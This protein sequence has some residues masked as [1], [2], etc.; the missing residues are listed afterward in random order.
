M[1]TQMNNGR[2]SP[3]IV[4]EITHFLMGN[5][6]FSSLFLL[7][8]PLVVVV[9]FIIKKYSGSA[10]NLPPGPPPWPIIGN[11]H[12]IGESPQVS[13][14]MFA[15]QYGPLISLHLGTQLLVV[16]SSPEAAIGILKSHDHLLSCRSI[17]DAIDHGLAPFFFVWSTDCGQH[18]KSL[19]TLSRNEMFSVKALQAQSGLR[20]KKVDQMLGFLHGKKGQVVNIGDLVFTTTFNTL[21]NVF[22]GKDFLD[23]GDEHGIAGGLKEKLNTL[24]AYGV[25]PNISDFFPIFK[26][27]DLQG[28]RK[29]HMKGMREVFSIWEHLIDERRAKY[30]SSMTVVEDKDKSFL[31]RL[32][33]S[34]FT[35]D[36]IN[37]CAIDLFIAGTDTTSSTVEWAMAELLK[38]KEAMNKLQEELKHKSD[39]NMI[40]ESHLS[41]FP[42]LN[43]CIKE[44]LRLHPP[45]PLLIPRHASETCEVMN[46]TIPQNTKIF[47]NVW[48]IGRDPKIW[49]DPL[50]FKPE[51]FLGSSLDFKGQDFEFIPFGAGRR[52]CPGTQYGIKSVQSILA[53]LIHQFDWVLPNDDDPTKLDM[54]EKF[55]V[56]LQREKPLQLIV[57]DSK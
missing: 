7:L 43:A 49:E 50:S 19:R 20:H 53:S 31:D 26:R 46:Y 23:F 39:S 40:T 34:G 37:I 25:R 52:M 51:R 9:F 22:F 11:I 14:A 4:M 21:S 6:L 48:T 15:Q 44:T 38:N 27:W 17:P 29:R 55:G 41:K 16:A 13:M 5:G 3:N 10:K 24:L 56:T 36:Q 57:K 30:S 32:L 35:N 33:E 45:A 42:Y 2:D 12:Q 47:V 18:W 28:L 54:N 8:T 1:Y